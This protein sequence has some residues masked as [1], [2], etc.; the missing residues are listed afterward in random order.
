MAAIAI[1]LEPVDSRLF[2]GSLD[3]TFDPDT[4]EFGGPDGDVIDQNVKLYQS[5]GYTTPIMCLRWPLGDRITLED[6][7]AILCPNWQTT[8][9]PKISFDHL[10]T[11]NPN[12]IY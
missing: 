4:Q 2:S 7:T 1:H 5:Q 12:V 8:D 6:L 9:L 11:Y 3:F 10:Y